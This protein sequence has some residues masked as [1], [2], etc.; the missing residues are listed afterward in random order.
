M[1]APLRAVALRGSVFCG[2]AAVG[3]AYYARLPRRSAD[4]RTA[5]CESVTT[6]LYQ[7]FAAPLVFQL[8][9]ETAHQLALRAAACWQ[10]LRLLWEPSWTGATPLDWLLRPGPR[11]EPAWGPSLRQELFG[12]RLRFDSP[13]GIAAGFD[14]N[15]EL[16]P[17][18]RLGLLP[19]LGFAEVGSISAE[20]AAGNPRPRCF[21]V[22]EDCAVVNRMGLNNDGSAAVAA[23]LERFAV[24]G[25]AGA[26]PP[27]GLQRAPVGVNIA[28]T[29]SPS[30]L[31]EAAVADFVASF[32]ALAPHADFVVLNVSCP[33]TEE[34]KTFED[35]EP[36]AQL[37]G[38]VGGARSAAFAAG[39]APPVLVK[40]SPPPDT[41][42]GHE[43]LRELVSVVEAAGFVEGFVV[44]NTAGDRDVPLSAAGRQAAK[45]VGRGGLSGRPLQAR[46]TA[47][48]RTV[49][50][51][52]GG[53]L[54][55][56]GVGG[57]DS[58]EAA[59]EKIRAGAS[60]VELYSSIVYKGPGVVEDVEV[61]LRRLLSRD[62]F[63]S[64]AAAVGADLAEE[65]ASPAPR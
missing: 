44:S 10:R 41:P 3:A 19:G 16:V 4:P 14:K 38:A 24:L 46:S 59:Y 15:A 47:A 7:N 25:R 13:V 28:K 9:P 31:G 17:L 34:G 54:P 39:A 43:R 22:V 5:S 64:I 33:N 37:L 36:L 1:A 58:A 51:C 45:D 2:A 35:P 20:P 52:T 60:L 27:G 53:R 6:R 30:I 62:G 12:G 32:Q 65:R 42:A 57:V 23:R 56:I 61:G 26:P 63:T 49:Y 29:H 40:L 11:S 21:R 8:E 55:I 18:Y 50:A 48:V